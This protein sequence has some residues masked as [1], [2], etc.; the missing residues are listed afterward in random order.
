MKQLT[1]EQAKSV[2]AAIDF[3][4]AGSAIHEI[5]RHLTVNEAIRFGLGMAEYLESEYTESEFL[6]ADF[7]QHDPPAPAC[8]SPALLHLLGTLGKGHWSSNAARAA[9]MRRLVLACL[10]S[11]AYD[12]GILRFTLGESLATYA[13]GKALPKALR[14]AAS[15]PIH[16]VHRDGLMYA[17][18]F[19]ELDQTVAAN[20]I[21]LRVALEALNSFKEEEGPGW[22]A[23]NAAADA[24]DI[25]VNDDHAEDSF[26]NLGIIDMRNL[27][28][29][30][31]S[32]AVIPIK[33]DEDEIEFTIVDAV[34][35]V[36]VAADAVFHAGGL[37]GAQNRDDMLN[38][39]AA[40]VID[41][42]K[43]LLPDS[44]MKWL[45]LAEI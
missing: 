28:G 12:S 8:I 25:F 20:N 11:A 22:R 32:L 7:Q 4:I 36:A 3:G 34:L 19:C 2:L 13:V 24:C 45:P 41:Q 37:D 16:P 6:T 39:F 17:A 30:D 33:I 42:V 18:A 14:A 31:S 10:N 35:T 43:S 26:D 40:F 5:D 29:E 21:A 38:E 9:G 1:P 15:Q 23:C 27:D 44:A